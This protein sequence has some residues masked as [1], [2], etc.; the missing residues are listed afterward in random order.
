MQFLRDFRSWNVLLVE[1]AL[2]ESEKIF[3]GKNSIFAISRKIFSMREIGR[4][5]GRILLWA[6]WDYYTKNSQWDLS[7]VESDD[8]YLALEGIFIKLWNF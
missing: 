5:V 4:I 6:L 3:D 7:D 8:I 1:D 2:E